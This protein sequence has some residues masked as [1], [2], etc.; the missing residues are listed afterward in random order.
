MANPGSPE[1]KR[2]GC[3]C[4]VLDNSYG[5]GAIVEGKV[6]TEQFYLDENC[7]IHTDRRRVDDGSIGGGEAAGHGH[8]GDAPGTRD[9]SLADPAPANVS[10]VP[11]EGSSLAELPED[12]GGRTEAQ[13]DRTETDR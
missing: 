12:L 7:P 2:L 1:A 8:D 11:G 13:G 10:L 6:D 4:P 5:E 9:H 3:T